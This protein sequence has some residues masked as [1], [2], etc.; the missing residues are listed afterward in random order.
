MAIQFQIRR[1]NTAENTS[2]VGA[3]GE[4][5]MNTETTTLRV[6]DGQHAGGFY[7]PTI[8]AEQKP[9]SNNGYTWFKK[10]S[11]GWVE[12][13][14]T[15]GAATVNLLI[16]MSDNNYTLVTG[17]KSTQYEQLAVVGKTTTSFTAKNA[18]GGGVISFDWL[19]CGMAAA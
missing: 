15:N 5:T 7:I 11:S 10:Y 4:M 18:N 14:G 16:P 3:P 9:T 6:H 8:V 1:G 19:V 17:N 13:G 2:F 12:Q